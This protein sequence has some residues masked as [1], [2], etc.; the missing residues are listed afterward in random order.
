M[1]KTVIFVGLL[2][3]LVLVQ[4]C[5]KDDE[6][7]P[8]PTVVGYWVGK[9][10]NGAGAAT[11]DYAFLFRADGTLKVYAN[12]TDTAAAAKATGT[13]WI[14]GTKVNTT[15]TYPGNMKYSSAS[16]ADENFTTMSGTW[17]SG[18][19]TTGNTFYLNKK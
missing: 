7:A 17:G 16:T 19:V 8:A 9:Y 12:N 6:A 15:Y 10:G 14:S 3:T 2:F 5:K 1:E 4:S 13:Y 11:L 18:T